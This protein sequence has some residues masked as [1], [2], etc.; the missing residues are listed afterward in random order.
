MS[1][2]VYKAKDQNGKLVDDTIQSTSREDAAIALKSM[3]LQVLTIKNLDNGFSGFRGSISVAEKAVFCRFMA[4]MLRSGLSIP[5][6][7][8]I[9]RSETKNKKMAKVMA[10]L[11]Y[12][13]QKGKSL[14]SV[15]ANYKDDFDQTFLTMIRVGEESGTLDKAFE[16]LTK[17]LNASYDLSQKVKGAMMYPAVIVVAMFGNGLLMMLFVLPR[18][19]SVF[20]KLDVPLPLPTKVILT[21]GDLIGKNVPLFLLFVGVSA[22]LTFLIFYLRKSRKAVL[23][24]ILRLPVVA[25]IVKQIDI[26]RFSRTLSTLLKSGVPI[27]T[28]LDVSSGSLSQGMVQSKLKNLSDSVAKGETLS[29]VLAKNTNLF[30]IIMVQT[31]K[32]GEKTGSLEEVLSEMADFYESEVDY[33]LKRATALLEP[34]LMLVIG[35]VVGAMVVIMIAPIYGIIGGLQQQIGN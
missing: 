9:I 19:S 30:P 2:F 22:F 1:L 3:G 15:L 29:S 11:S 8:E 5:E 14:S 31:I 26:A 10:D 24:I 17:Q 13:T 27:T 25:K 6:A 23:S 20:L 16:Y 34:V 32:A 12:Q 35:V 33:S 28:A 4:T 18:I 7:I 21:V